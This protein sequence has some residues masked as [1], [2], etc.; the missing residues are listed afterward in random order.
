[1]SLLAAALLGIVE[2]VTEFLPV[3]STGH[4]IL[5]EKLFGIASTDAVKSFDIVIQ[6]GAISAALVVF[7]QTLLLNRRVLVRVL[8][9]FVPTA[10]AGALLHHTVK[11]YLLDP[12]VV[13][14]ALFV[15]GIFIIGFELW[16][17]EQP[18][19]TAKVEDITIG[20][21]V[22]IGILQTLALIPGT[23]RSAATIIGGMALGV[24]RAAI[25]D[26]SFLLAIPTMAGATALDLYKSSAI[27]TSQDLLTIG[28]GFVMSFIA[29]YAAIRWLLRYVR[30]HT[31]LAFGVYRIIV[32]IL[33]WV[34][35]LKK[36]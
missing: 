5:A 31:F 3:S 19:A 21:A 25:V 26:F 4:L 28:V 8:C 7:W 2:G 15:G 22:M 1:M 29:A 36:P 30:T 18:S 12:S 23:S 20:K 16:F 14:W 13:A 34:L 27:L 11:T 9:A 6:L 10:I 35:V 32:A 24:R 17:R 33:F